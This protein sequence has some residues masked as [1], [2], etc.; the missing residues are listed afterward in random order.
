MGKGQRPEDDWLGSKE[1]G[2]RDHRGG[3][4]VSLFRV[5]PGRVAGVTS[6]R[7]PVPG[8]PCLEA[9]PV[10]WFFGRALRTG[11]CR[12][13]QSGLPL[14]PLS[15]HEGSAQSYCHRVWTPSLWGGHSNQLRA[16]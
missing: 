16:S 2:E 9:S 13:A 8:S 10:P 5:T 4:L 3:E 15:G 7:P 6:T 12:P 11:F 14:G 1:S